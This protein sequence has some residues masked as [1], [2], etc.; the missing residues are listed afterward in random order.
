MNDRYPDSGY[1]ANVCDHFKKA[2]YII[3][4]SPELLCTN[5]CPFYLNEFLMTRVLHRCDLANRDRFPG[6][7]S[8]RRSLLLTISRGL[9]TSGGGILSHC[10]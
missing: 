4:K 8:G 6:I 9:L 1:T 2:F 5:N 3:V 10:L 7:E